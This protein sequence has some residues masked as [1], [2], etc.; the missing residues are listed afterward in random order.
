MKK[1]II[2]RSGKRICS[3]GMERRFHGESWYAL[4]SK[5]YSDF[6]I[7]S[8]MVVSNGTIEGKEMKKRLYCV[9]LCRSFS[10]FSCKDRND[11][12]KCFNPQ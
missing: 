8:V 6:L 7:E 1:D 12:E 10:S 11:R 2:I 4:F 3:S 5:R 9:M